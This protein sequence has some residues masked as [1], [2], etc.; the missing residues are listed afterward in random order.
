MASSSSSGLLAVAVLAALLAG[1]QCA[2]PKVTFTVEKGS[3]EKHL[4]VLVKYEGDSMAEV[5]LREHSS[6]E[7][8]AMVKTDGDV[9]RFES[10]EPLQGPF[11]FR[12][13][14]VKGM[15][16]V[17]DDVIPAKYTVGA[18]YTPEQY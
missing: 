8:V 3:D 14:T 15:K 11:N 4:A 16:N 12:F 1:A 17:F 7:W 6:N 9:W 13:L 5:E 18:T 2:A 10:E